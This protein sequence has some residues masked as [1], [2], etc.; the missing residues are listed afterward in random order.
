MAVLVLLISG[1]QLRPLDY[2][3]IDTAEVNIITSWEHSGLTQHPNGQTAMFFPQSGGTPIVKLSHS[4]TV[5]VNLELGTYDVIVIN[6]TFEDFDYIEFVSRNSFRDIAAVLSTSQIVR[7][8]YEVYEEPDM[9]ASAVLTN[10]EVTESMVALTRDITRARTKTKS[11]TKTTTKADA[12]ESM[13]RTLM[14]TLTWHVEP[15]PLVYDVNVR[16]K[17]SGLDKVYSSGS[18]ITGFSYGVYLCDG[19]PL[20]ESVTHKLTY[21]ERVYESGSDSEGYLMGHFRSFGFH[22]DGQSTHSDYTMDFRAVVPD[23][24]TY[25]EIRSLDNSTAQSYEAYTINFS[26]NVGFG[27]GVDSPIDI[28]E[29]APIEG[30]GGWQINVGQWQEEVIPIDM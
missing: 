1:C 28:P 11:S 23:G 18:F 12:N 26:V 8:G 2:D 21:T 3:Y 29:I 30:S 17:V 16:V 27:T 7:T 13:T 15:T 24:S 10:F 6:E 5:T 4:D 19:S 14:P 22:D 25:S 9:L 20:T